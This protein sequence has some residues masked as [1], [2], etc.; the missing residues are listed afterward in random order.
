MRVYR[1]AD[2]AGY[3]DQRDTS[4][5]RSLAAWAASHN[6]GAPLSSS[7]DDADPWLAAVPDYPGDPEV[8]A[9][10]TTAHSQ[11]ITAEDAYS[12]DDLAGG[13]AATKAAMASI[14]KAQKTMTADFDRALA[15]AGPATAY[16]A[17]DSGAYLE[18]ASLASAATVMRWVDG[19]TVE[20]SQGR[21][22][23]VGVDTPEV[24]ETCSKAG[25]ATANAERLA[26]PGTM[27]TLRNP[28]SVQETDK[29]GRLLRYVE[30]SDHDVGYSQIREGLGIARYDATDGYDS[31]PRQAAYHA[32][33][34]GTPSDNPL[35]YAAAAAAAAWLLSAD[36]DEHHLW[37]L[38]PG[39]QS[40]TQLL[41]D[42]DWTR[43]V[44]PTS[45]Q[46]LGGPTGRRHADHGGTG[47][48]GSRCECQSRSQEE[49]R[50][51]RCSQGEGQ[52]RG[53]REGSE[54]SVE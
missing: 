22:R 41:L 32:S 54:G 43:A 45:T 40:T 46:L 15:K 50:S 24:S 5:A 34:R 52:S 48:G 2:A 35:C 31:H 47:Q 36:D 44:D 1:S 9:L 12:G 11:R 21:V 4:D 10:V 29:Y 6:I 38:T 49:G 3:E 8:S 53:S 14:T 30:V 26:P 37:V 28:A 27:V 20:T 18:V 51:R 42:A 16:R 17:A 7:T 13:D 19:D 39:Q 25:E 23:L 33:S